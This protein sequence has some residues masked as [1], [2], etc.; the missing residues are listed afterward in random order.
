MIDNEDFRSPL[1]PGDP[2]LPAG[3]AG[4]PLLVGA[5]GN[6]FLVWVTNNL[7]G[8]TDSATIA[9]LREA[10]VP[11]A[12]VRPTV[13]FITPAPLHP[14]TLAPGANVVLQAT[15]TAASG[16][17]RVEFLDGSSSLGDAVLVGDVYELPYTVPAVSVTGGVEG[18]V[19]TPPPTT[20]RLTAKATAA[21]GQTQSA[22]TYFFVGLVLLTPPAPTFTHFVDDAAGGSVQLVPAPGVPMADY[23]Y[24][25]GPDGVEVAVPLNGVIAVGNVAGNVYAF[26]VA[27]GNRA[28]SAAASSGLFTTTAQLPVV[29]FVAPANGSTLAQGTQILIRVSATDPQPG[30]QITAVYLYNAGQPIGVATP[31]GNLWQLVYTVPSTGNILTLTARA[32]SDTDAFREVSCQVFLS[33]PV[34]EYTVPVAPTNVAGTAG[35]S[36][37]TVSW[38]APVNTN[39][40]PITSYNVYRNGG[41]EA[42]ATT[43]ATSYTDSTAVNG[44]AYTYQVAAVNSEGE[45]PR[46]AATAALTP[47]APVSTY[48]AT[49]QTYLTTATD[50]AAKCGAGTP[51]AAVSKTS[52]NATSTLNQNDANSKALADAT[53]QAIAAIVCAVPPPTFNTT[54]NPGDNVSTVTWNA[55]PGVL[56]RLNLPLSTNTAPNPAT[57]D[58]FAP[59]GTAIGSAS[60]N[61]ADTGAQAAVFYNGTNHL[62]S[63]TNGNVTLS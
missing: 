17:D 48:T 52:S 18:G 53:A 4:T 16:I 5:I 29:S 21:N 19:D 35:N 1:P 7:T 14:A 58:V 28:R 32:I 47:T 11:S 62:I 34:R 8:Q 10:F 20:R 33:P 13:A 22:T 54:L 59:D 3:M 46:S 37:V 25:V 9:Q 23:R 61:G 26:S 57:M 36:V 24:Q 15:A 50:Y 60:Y 44:T 40:A 39:N 43:A 45:G 63:L 51:T 27:S 49:P 12:A 55:A 42:L 2:N 31:V 41:L 56:L 6:D 30:A 38:T